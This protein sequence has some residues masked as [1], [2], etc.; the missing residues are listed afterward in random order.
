M[1][2]MKIQGAS[3]P[4]GPSF[5][6][7][8]LVNIFFYSDVFTFKIRELSLVPGTKSALEVSP[9]LSPF[10]GIYSPMFGLS[11]GQYGKKAFSEKVNFGKRK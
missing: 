3:I 8:G 9:H 5:A 4:Q 11:M 6:S 1:G 10:L 7:K 2:G